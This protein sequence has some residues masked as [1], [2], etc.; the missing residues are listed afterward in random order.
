MGF[1]KTSL[2]VGDRTI[3]QYLRE[4]FHWR[5]PVALITAPG[6]EKPAGAQVF[7]VESVDPIAG[8]GPLRG[9]LTALENS[10]TGIV[11]VATVD[12]PLASREQFDWL[13]AQLKR[14]TEKLGIMLSRLGNVEPFPSAYRIGAADVIR[15]QINAHKLA[16]RSLLEQPAFERVDA[17]TDWDERVWT[18]LNTPGDLQTFAQMNHGAGNVVIPRSDESV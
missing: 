4:R 3:L 1:P 8:L 18:N 9:I 10:T 16:I 2:R 12:M 6:R 5:G 7:D 11:V 13:V 17:P 14:R 15:R